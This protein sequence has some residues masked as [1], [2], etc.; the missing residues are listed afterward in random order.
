MLPKLG[1]LEAKMDARNLRAENY[2]TGL[3]SAP[4]VRDWGLG[5]PFDRRAWC[6]DWLGCCVA[7]SIANLLCAMAA[8]AGVTIRITE[9]DV[10]E[11]YAAI[12]GWDGRPETDTGAY[13]LDGCKRL[14]NDGLGRFE[15][16]RPLKCEA[17]VSVNFFNPTHFGAAVECYGGVVV[18]E[19][20]PVE[21]QG[22]DTWLVMP[23]MRPGSWGGHASARWGVSPAIYNGKSWT[24]PIY[25][26]PDFLYACGDE[27][28]AFLIPDLAPPSGLDLESLRADLQALR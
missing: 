1:K 19:R 18:G 3:P 10:K 27:A 15:D 26:E 4:A 11:F 22:R 17:F 20:L 8:R 25:E 21:A 23:G 12:S 7:A 5:L 24:G 6:N 14:R 28:Y 2:F 16:G 13:L 9:E